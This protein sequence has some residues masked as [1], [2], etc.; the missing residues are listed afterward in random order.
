[1]KLAAEGIKK[2]ISIFWDDS[3]LLLLL[4]FVC[5]LTV[6]PA[7][8]FYTITGSNVSVVTA[9]LNSLLFLPLVFFL[10][11]LSAVL[12][13]GRQDMVISFRTTFRHLRKRWKQALIFGVFNLFFA[14]L[15]G[16]NL[17]FYGQFEAAWAGVFQWLFI[18][19]SLVWVTLQ[20]VML[21]LYPRLEEPNFRTAL[22]NAVAI[23]GRYP[24]P[25]LVLVV[26]TAA[27]LLL[28]YRLQALGA[29]FTFVLICALAEGIVGE[30]VNADIEPPL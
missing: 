6:L 17:T 13:D 15:V 9:V 19:I 3:I 28:T 4:N 23:T 25:V 7:L 8:L 16:W 2:S 22:R 1:M 5:F 30:I 24:V 29:L 18:S 21:P 26:C 20:L 14:L 11:A 27:L 12:Y 10:F